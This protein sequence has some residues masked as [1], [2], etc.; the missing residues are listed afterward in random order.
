MIREEAQSP[1]F[2][3][4]LATESVSLG[5]GGSSHLQSVAKAPKWGT[6]SVLV[7]G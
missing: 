6:P 3:M 7:R 5:P 1:S 2:Q 4:E